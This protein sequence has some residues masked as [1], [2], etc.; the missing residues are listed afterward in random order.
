[1]G[2][3]EPPDSCRSKRN[4]SV[5]NWAAQLD[6]PGKAR[7]Y[8]RQ[9]GRGGLYG[10]YPHFLLRNPPALGTEWCGGHSCWAEP[11]SADTGPCRTFCLADGVLQ[12]GISG[13]SRF[14]VHIRSRTHHSIIYERSC[15]H[16]LRRGLPSNHLLRQS[17]LRLRNGNG[18]VLQWRRGYIYANDGEPLRILAVSNPV[19]V[20]ACVLY[21]SGIEGRLC[22]YSDRRNRDC[23]YG[24][25]AV[26]ARNL[27]DEENLKL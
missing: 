19:G 26:S 22:R 6:V 2:R 7:E 23:H 27:E 17:R 8:F 16:R 15:R 21:T 25:D 13:R 1:M 18:A 20:L 10:C 9:R 14:S 3:H 12:H 11:G 24:R 4:V 5:R